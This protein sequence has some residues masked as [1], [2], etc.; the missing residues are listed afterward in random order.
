[1]DGFSNAVSM[2]V[3]QLDVCVRESDACVDYE[4]PPNNFGSENCET[5]TCSHICET[6]HIHDTHSHTHATHIPFIKILISRL[7]LILGKWQSGKRQIVRL[8][9]Q[10]W[11]LFKR[12]IQATFIGVSA[13]SNLPRI[14]STPISGII[15]ILLWHLRTK[16]ENNKLKTYLIL[17]FLRFVTSKSECQPSPTAYKINQKKAKIQLDCIE[18]T[19]SFNSLTIHLIIITSVQYKYSPAWFDSNPFLCRKNKKKIEV[20]RFY[21]WHAMRDAREA[22]K[23]SNTLEIESKHFGIS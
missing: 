21:A 6:I 20:V 9:F 15:C 12:W 8:N 3:S 18:F 1:M 11:K 13:E 10:N 2:W 22:Q 17:A 7:Q 4:N 16:S 5:K 23:W 19:Y 14:P